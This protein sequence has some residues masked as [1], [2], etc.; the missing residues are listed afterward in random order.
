MTKKQLPIPVKDLSSGKEGKA[1]TLKFIPQSFST[2]LIAQATRILGQRSRIR[3]AH[4]KD[5]SEVRGGGRRPWKQKGTGRARHSSIRSP[6]WTGGGIT[7]GPRSRRESRKR[8]PKKQWSAAIAHALAAQATNKALTIVDFPK[9]MPTK[10]KD[11]LAMLAPTPGTLL[12]LAD[13]NAAFSAVVRNLP[14]MKT[15]IASGVTVAD[16]ATA[17]SVLIDKA[18]LPALEVRCSVSE[19]IAV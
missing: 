4:S 16:I 2:V 17:T 6:L 12:I 18:A 1:V 5:R 19:K 15:A 7:F 3:R 10:T 9:E 11:A 14:E 8:L 13:D